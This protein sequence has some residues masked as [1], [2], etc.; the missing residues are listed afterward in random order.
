MKFTYRWGQRPLEGFTIKRGLGHG[1]F[2]EV[3]FAVSDGGKEVAIK[4]I[5]GHTDIELRGIANCLNLKHPHLVHLYDL[6]VD[7]QGD[8]WL[9][10]E[11]VQGEPLNAIL[12]RHPHGM[13]EAQAR[14]WFL[15]AARAVEYLHDHAVVHRDIK[16]ANLFLEN[17]IVK[18]GDYGL[19]KSVGSSQHSQSSNV[20]T[21]HYMAPEVASGAYSK[22]IDVYACGVMLYEML[23]GEVPFKGESWAEIAIKHQTDLPDMSKAPAAY[24]PVLERALN[25]RVDRRFADMTEMIRATEAVGQLKSPNPAADQSAP[26]ER[27]PGG[28]KLPSARVPVP[29]PLKS[30]PGSHG[31]LSELVS[32]LFLAPVAAV[33][34]TAV[35]AMFTGAVKWNDLGSL[36][37]IMV[38]VSWAVLIPA[39]IWEGSQ[40]SA[41]RRMLLIALGALIGFIAFGLHGWTYP[42]LQLSDDVTPPG[43]ETIW[44]G[45]LRTEIG[46]LNAL[47]G[48]ILYFALALGIPRWW[49]AVERKRPERFTLYPLIAA[50]LCGLLLTWFWEMR[51]GPHDGG[52]PGYFV[53]AL[54]GAAAVVQV[55]SRWAPPSPSTTRFRRRLAGAG[56]FTPSGRK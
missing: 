24:V 33:P 34:A 3:Y 9:V 54:A 11:Y 49:Q 42:Q 16:P 15:Q 45:L 2:G 38:M 51:I 6:K 53:L 21:I 7:S 31:K 13:P 27:D 37:L 12:H 19:S 50:G 23:T 14:E 17:G 30:T 29:E 40:T 25:K 46:G 22:Q 4:L 5:R 56:S 1:G 10:M 39:K 20:G 8:R 41:P 28:A 44:G 47:V 18:L 48:Y 35:W 43:R 52:A 26:W 55:V 32:A 36:F